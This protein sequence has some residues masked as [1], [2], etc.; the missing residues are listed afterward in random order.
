MWLISFSL[1]SS[2]LSLSLIYNA[3]LQTYYGADGIDVDS[4]TDPTQQEALK[5]MV[6]TYGQMPLQLFKE[7]HPPRSKSTVRTT[8]LIRFGS[9]FKRLTSSS[10]APLKINNSIVSSNMKLIKPKVSN[11]CVFIGQPDP[12]FSHRP[13]VTTPVPLSPERLTCLWNG[14][15]AITD[16]DASF[17]PSPS[18]T[19][20]SL[21][22][23]WGH[24]DNAVLIRSVTSE[25]GHTVKLSNSPLNRVSRFSLV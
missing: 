4:I 9:I 11:N 8:L 21:L 19:Y 10:S 16:Q 15:V 7:S 3:I 23:S 13:I 22:V 12:P 20:N 2:S 25:Y 18:S 5:T 6:K 1:S 24:W 14:E 17:F